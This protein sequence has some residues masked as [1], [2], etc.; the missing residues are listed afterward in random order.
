MS[1]ID[2]ILEF[3]FGSEGDTS[4]GKFREEWFTAE[5][6][7]DREIRERFLETY[8][9]A[10]RGKLDHWRDD[11]RS[12]LALV[13]VLGQFSRNMF[14]GSAGMYETDGKALAVA[15]G[16]LEKGY[17]HELPP[18][19]RWFLHMPF[20]HSEDVGDQRRAVE[21]FERLEDHQPGDDRYQDWHLKTIE[22]FG[23]FPH[24]NGILGRRSTPG[25]TEFLE[26]QNRSR[27]AGR[28]QSE[29][30]KRANPARSSGTT[31]SGRERQQIAAV[32]E[33]YRRGFA[34]MDAEALKAIWD[35]DYDN[36]IYIAQ[37]AAEPVLGWAGIEQYYEGAA[38]FL[39][40]VGAMTVS[41]LSVDVLG[42]VAYAFCAFH[43]EGELEGENHIADGRDTF[44]LRREGGEWKVIHYHESPPG[45]VPMTGEGAST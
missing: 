19:Q 38:G 36:L 10:R 34:T 29:Q 9:Q 24:R 31:A 11:S 18:F 8:S 14:R 7:F 26:E 17:D 44:I 5:P 6:E 3:W 37:E 30:A 15:G 40:R 12:A 32:V 21:L 27:A 39:G 23:R 16:A 4:Y 2:E 28:H 13:I 41:D 20:V 35:R 42:D 22:R 43:F 25:E 33:R 1:K 45:P